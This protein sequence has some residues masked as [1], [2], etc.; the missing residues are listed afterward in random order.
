MPQKRPLLHTGSDA[1]DM[2]YMVMFDVEL[3]VSGV[4]A[5]NWSSHPALTDYT[6]NSPRE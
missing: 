5:G 2:A 4:F 1:A 6:T 3:F